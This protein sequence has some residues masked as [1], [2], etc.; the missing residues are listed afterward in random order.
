[1]EDIMSHASSRPADR[2][3]H[4]TTSSLRSLDPKAVL[5][6][7]AMGFCLLGLPV[8]GAPAAARTITAELDF[9]APTV[10]TRSGEAHIEMSDCI[11]LGAPGLPM[12]PARRLVV[13]LPPGE[14]VAAVR[15]RAEDASVLGEAY[16]V[17]QAQAPRPISLPGDWPLTEPDA[18]VYAS[19]DT[20]PAAAARLV[21]VQRASGHGLAFLQVYPTTW[22]PIS[23]E[24]TWYGRVTVEVE[25]RPSPNADP[26]RIA[27]LRKDEATCRR[28]ER[29]V[30]NPQDLALYD[31]AEPA[32]M[33]GGRVDPDYYPYVIITNDTYANAFQELAVYESSRGLRACVV[34]LSEIMPVYQG[35]DLAEQIRNFILDAYT[36]WGT[37]Y[38]LLG[39]DRS[40]IPVR[41]LYVDAG[42]TIDRFPG[43]CY[44]EGLDGDW[45]DDGDDRWGEMNEA[46]LVNEVVVGRASID[47][48]AQ[49]SNWLHKN[50]MYAE[51]PVVSEIHRALFLGEQLDATT[52]GDDSMDEVK[53]HCT[54]HGYETSGYPET[55]YKSMLYDRDTTYTASDVIARFNAGYPSSH[56][57]GH[58]NTT[59]NMKMSNGDVQYLTNDGITSSFPVIYSQGCYAN[60]FDNAGSDAISEVFFYDNNGAAAFL[61]C[62]RYGWYTPGS[63]N[64]PSQH[65]DRQWVDACYDEDIVTLGWM[66][67]DSKL[68]CLWLLDNYMLWCHYELCLLGDPALT[69]WRDLHGQ[70]ALAHAGTY[71]LGQ[72]AYYVTVTAGGQ[73]VS[74][75]T[76]TLYSEDLASWGSA[77]TG[78]DGVAAVD[79]GEVA[80]TTLHLKAIKPDYLPVTDEVPAAPASGPYLV[81]AAATYLD[82]YGSEIIDAGE[83]AHVRVL[84]RNVGPNAALAV[85]ATVSTSDPYVTLINPVRAYPNIAPG[86]ESWGTGAFDMN[87]APN[88]P[89]LHRVELT[90]TMTCAGRLSWNAPLEFEVHAPV[91]SVADIDIDDSVGGNGNYRLEPGE[92][93]TV[94]IWLNNAGTGML[95]SVSGAFTCS[96]PLIQILSGAG[97]IPTG[98]GAG[99]TKV[100]APPFE[101][102]IDPAFSQFEGEF[103]LA[104]S[105]SLSFAQNIEIVLP[106]GGYFENVE[107]GAGEWA[108][109]PAQE[110]WNDQ[111][112]ITTQQNHT[113][114]GSHSWKCGSTGTGPYADHMDAA[115][116]TPVASLGGQ[117]QLVFWHRIDAE[118]SSMYPGQAYDGGRV[119]MS[120]DGGD[121]QLIEP[122]GGYTHIVR[123]RFAGPGPFETGSPFFSGT[124]EWTEVTFD[125]AGVSGDVRFRFRFGSD[126]ASG[127]DGW[128]IDDIIIVGVSA[129]SD[130]EGEPAAAIRLSLAPSRPNPTAGA[131]RIAFALPNPQRVEL[132]VFD[133]GGR[134]VRTLLSGE[135]AAGTHVAQW[136]GCDEASRPVVSGCYYCRLVTAEGSRRQTMV[137]LR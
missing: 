43:E 47:T 84:L 44:Y 80:P 129:M 70:L 78:P 113:Q 134:L 28:I 17:P 93:A 41:T 126:Y 46:D 136:D 114:N 37:Q 54:T 130:A 115:L 60:N 16:H 7:A 92:Q 89:D 103:A 13:L 69:Q 123:N 66:N 24:L 124:A 75:A 14:E 85:T 57:L 34:R 106:I 5:A 22:R 12:L 23:G 107:N 82:P 42:G 120:V 63:T 116:E 38:V 39:G 117:G 20:Y 132:Q 35:V 1:L 71:T 4:G 79:P 133:T 118:A 100:M 2:R 26:G 62:T 6:L 131:T 64:G 135:L 45:N 65:F 110:G 31:A 61:G 58:S 18:A 127:E 122:V 121:W 119:E 15:A 90:L 9:T 97:A 72:G 91:I 95:Q 33:D 76:V 109:A 83:A 32:V 112:H 59:Y 111:W 27:L 81:A 50:A 137:V 88:C 25:T 125:L 98:V 77:V 49:L 3:A 74:G 55:Y 8:W 29:L 52:W 67:A 21:T 73:P 53:D 99:E 101:V 87:I 96:H 10:S 108:H 30:A 56:H 36:L 11:T 19:D 86:A 51:A 105:G 40:I 102:A 48:Q 128:F 104:L 68:D 94:S